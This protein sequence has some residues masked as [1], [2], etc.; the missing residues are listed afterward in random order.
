MEFT[1]Y[2]FQAFALV[3]SALFNS[4]VWQTWPID[5]T[6]VF[7]PMIVDSSFL[8]IDALASVLFF[9]T[10][11]NTRSDE[12]LEWGMTAIPFIILARTLYLGCPSPSRILPILA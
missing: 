1:V 3:S 6:L 5:I 12:A 4:T 11:L 10:R 9:L 8:D 2:C 7:C